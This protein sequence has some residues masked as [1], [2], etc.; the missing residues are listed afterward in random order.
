LALGKE[1]NNL[2]NTIGSALSQMNDAYCDAGYVPQTEV[3]VIDPEGI[4]FE[5]ENIEYDSETGQVKVT[6]VPVDE[7]EMQ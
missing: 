7:E 2:D 6:I 1:E 5:F 3:V 4:A